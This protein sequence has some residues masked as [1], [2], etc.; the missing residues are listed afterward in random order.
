MSL[1]EGAVHCIREIAAVVVARDHDRH[2]GWRL[3]ACC[4]PH[5]HS[6]D[7][8]AGVRVR[9]SRKERQGAGPAAGIEDKGD[10]IARASSCRPTAREDLAQV[11]GAMTWSVWQPMVAASSPLGDRCV[12]G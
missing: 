2:H 5:V 1:G 6:C 12:K 7:A 3:G 8:D 4:H 11:G 10:R 9:T